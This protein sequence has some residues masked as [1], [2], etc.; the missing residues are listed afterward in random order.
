MKKNSQI[1]TEKN[2]WSIQQPVAL[3][4]FLRPQN[5]TYNA[6]AHAEQINATEN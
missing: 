3:L 2:C 5:G 6:T 4:L 1:I